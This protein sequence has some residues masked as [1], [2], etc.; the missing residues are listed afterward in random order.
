MEQ[1][2]LGI[3]VA[4]NTV[5]MGAGIVIFLITL[6]SLFRTIVIPRSLNSTLSQ[7]V[8]AGVLV[9]AR[10][11]ARI[12]RTYRGRDAILAWSGP[13]FIFVILVTWLTLFVLAYALMIFAVTNTTSFGDAL[14]Q[15]GSSLLTLG[16]AAGKGDD[17]IFIDFMAAA[18][19]PIV[20]ALMI[21]VLPTI[22][23]LYLQREQ[24]VATLNSMAGDPAWG[25]EYIVRMSLT[26]NIDK[27]PDVFA[28]WS[29]WSVSVQLS[30]TTYPMLIHVRSATASRNYAV[31]LLV[32]MDAAALMISCSKKLPRSQAFLLLLNGSVAMDRLY[33]KAS[34]Q[35]SL[36]RSLPLAHYWRHT[37]QN[38]PANISVQAISPQMQA[39]QT[40][41]ARD[42]MRDL[43]PDDVATLE[44]GEEAP[45]QLTQDEFNRA[46]DMIKE[47]GF[48]VDRDAQ[49]AWTVFSNL[50]KRYEYA[51]YGL[52]RILY[53]T[54]APWTGDRSIST[55]VEWPN[56]A[57]PILRQQGVTAASPDDSSDPPAP[58][59]AHQ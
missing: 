57:I 30:H 16:F 52:M 25:P 20:I 34:Q 13:S 26:N 59:A 21:G 42:A 46:Y 14:A 9:T 50:R 1:L 38:H 54:P 27:L 35:Q 22:Y 58:D 7:V 2:P 47:S 4:V 40:A 24:P 53:A 29:Q 6:I 28:D 11:I 19:G 10:A 5:A 8:M 55:P 44:Q 31:A 36:R 32:M 37:E 3:T 51:A 15:S 43:T 49:T 45:I 41:A 39:A 18:T 56:L 48:P 17:Q 12:P 33:E 23:S